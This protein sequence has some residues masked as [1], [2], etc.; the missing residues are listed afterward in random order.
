MSS[1][2]ASSP[3]RLLAISGVLALSDP[4]SPFP[5]RGVSPSYSPPGLDVPRGSPLPS[6]DGYWSQCVTAT[7]AL[8]DP[9]WNGSTLPGYVEPLTRPP[10]VVLPVACGVESPTPEQ[11]APVEAIFIQEGGPVCGVVFLYYSVSDMVQDTDFDAVVFGSVDSSLSSDGSG[12]DCS[13]TPTFTRRRRASRKHYLARPYPARLGSKIMDVVAIARE[14]GV[15]A[16]VNG[17]VEVNMEKR[18][19]GDAF[20]RNLHSL[21]VMAVS[22]SLLGVLVVCW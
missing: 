13:S 17:E 18:T 7:G 22:Y 21:L 12:S 5:S 1:T 9:I 3:S 20:L 16:R 11:A 14:R 6:E 8:G 4:R 15:N 2:N 19:I 10:S